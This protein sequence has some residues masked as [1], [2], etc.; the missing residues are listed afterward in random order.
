M[1]MVQKQMVENNHLLLW[2]MGTA[3]A[4]SVREG[5]LPKFPKLRKSE[6]F[7]SLRVSCTC[8]QIFF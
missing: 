1:G 8:L 7:G 5:R 2:Q 6:N 3:G 4:G